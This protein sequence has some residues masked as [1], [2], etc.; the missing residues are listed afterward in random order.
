MKAWH[1]IIIV[2]ATFLGG[3]IIGYF[4]GNTKTESDEEKEIDKTFEEIERR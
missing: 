3:G 2:V 1:W 4:W